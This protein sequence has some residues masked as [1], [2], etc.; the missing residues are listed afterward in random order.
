MDKKKSR[1]GKNIKLFLNSEEGK[2]LDADI[3]KTGI[4]LGIIGA[5]MVDQAAA[6]QYP[7]H[8]NSFT[9]TQHSSHQSHGSHASHGSHGSHARGGWCG[10]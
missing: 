5:V 8:T 1:L 4:A 9:S 2:M 10:S 6:T 3:V 7:L